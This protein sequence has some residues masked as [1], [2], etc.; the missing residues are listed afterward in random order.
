MAVAGLL[1]CFGL[2][3]FLVAVTDIF[4]S[5][6]VGTA[7]EVGSIYAHAILGL[8]FMVGGGL[9]LW[10][11]DAAAQRSKE[12]TEKELPRWEKALQAWNR[13]FYCPRCA[14]VFDPVAGTFAAAP[15]M[16]QML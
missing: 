6:P 8:L 3:L 16:Y 4:R 13:L 14:H 12:R 9:L 2:L 5:Q 10:F 1:M 11:L 15:Q 7:N